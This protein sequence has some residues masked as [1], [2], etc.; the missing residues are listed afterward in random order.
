MITQ[1]RVLRQSSISAVLSIIHIKPFPNWKGIFF[2]F[3]FALTIS[4]FPQEYNFRN[5]NSAEGLPYS[6][7]YSINQ[8]SGG[9]LWIGTGNGLSRY[10]GFIFENYTTTDS[11]TD[12]FISCS[13]T[14]GKCMWFG[15]MSGQLSFFDGDKL[16]P[17]F[18][19]KLSSSPVTHFAKSPDNQI[20]ASTYSDGLLKLK[21]NGGSADHYISKDQI[22]IIS[23][24]FLG[25]NELLVGTNTG[26][27]LAR[28]NESGE[29]ERIRLF[30]EIPESKVTCIRKMR[31]KPGFY[32]ATEN[33][34]IFKITN[35]DNRLMVSKITE[36]RGFD[37]TGIQDIYE[38]SRS[39]LWLGSF[40]NGLIRI[41][42]S[43]TGETD[44][45]NYFNRSNGF[46]TDNVKTVFEDRE[47]N[48]WSGNYGEGLTQIMPRVFSVRTFNK[49]LYGNNIFS[50]FSDKLYRWIGTDNGL[51][52]TDLLTGKIA[53]FFSKG[54]GLP[55]DSVISIYSTDGKE[56][57]IG[58][59]K[60]G[61]F[62]METG[63]E[64]I[65]K[66][67]PGN[68]NLE[69][70]ITAITGKGEEVWI[71]TKKGL[72]CINS[73]TKSENWY[74]I[75]QG[76]LPHNYVNSLYIDKQ[77]RLWVTTRSNTLAY[78]QNSRVTKVPL[79]SGPGVLTLGPVTEDAENRIWVGSNG[80][81]VFLIEPDSI[82]N[83]TVKEG[84]LSN[85]CYSLICDEQKNIW[86][87]HKGGLSRIRTSDFSIKQLKSIEG[88]TESSRF[89]QNAID[90]DKTGKIWF[91]S[92]IGIVSYDPSLNN[93]RLFSPV[94]KI[95]SVKINDEEKDFS[96]KII[97]SPGNYKIRI[98]FLGISLK[99]P[100]LVTYQ[101][102]LEN[103]DQ[104]S[105][106]TKNTSI[107]YN[108]ITEGDYNFILKASSGDGI[109]T[110]NPLNLNIIIKKPIWKKWWFYVTAVIL[111]IG[112]I[113][114][115]IKRREYRFL[116]EKRLLEEKVR[117]RTY[118]IQCQKNEI[119]KQR[120]IIDEK[121][122]NITSSIR[123]ASHIQN[124]VLP[125][126]ERLNKL[127]PD[128]FIL[129][130]PKDIVSGDFYWLAEKDSKVI[131]AVADCTGHGVSGAFMSFLGIALLNEI[132]NIQ[133]ITRS[134]TIVTKLREAI[135]RS[136]QQTRKEIT[137]LDGIDI[138]LCVFDRQKRIIQYTGGMIDLLYFRDKKLVEVKADNQSV[139]LL[140]HDSGPFTQKEIDCRKGD[141]FYLFSDGFQDQF[142]GENNKKYLRHRFYCTLSEIHELTIPA[143]KESL[144]K[145]LNEWMRDNI[146]TDDITVMGFK[147]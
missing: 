119:E 102:K 147:L 54:S 101:Y 9:Y 87:G 114:T 59:E 109:V 11:L 55:K 13:V 68:E 22:F 25:N 61:V 133:G 100:E 136:L 30:T 26:L 80:N 3:F 125:D 103:Y 91:G 6:Y 130:R 106:I 24:D 81:G 56:L 62:L 37:I 72:C 121:N 64:R 99:E 36:N 145:T 76:G 118:E 127:L 16:H 31:S 146:Q 120:D 2:L 49:A 12:N 17:A 140:S 134:D 115:Y 96:D 50:I 53:K 97:L 143:Q 67:F 132:V 40:G 77:G 58:T 45:I 117:E 129:S 122:A 135:I 14:D 108:H 47:G 75:S 1:N 144:E 124:A 34:G 19:P 28:L 84:L 128:S 105:E 93:P 142:G 4:A 141:V 38:D 116:A 52:K 82:L 104:W 83:L 18:L 123:Y 131:F 10:N 60:N 8:D 21:R 111:I 63:S 138:G 29:I 66:Y 43:E 5:F 27:I 113:Y 48:I 70:S 46:L 15:H 89:N 95:I 98:D 7:V 69:N 86:V 107:I 42:F 88:I 20:W 137:T 33:D 73:V 41:I 85:Y 35:E 78:I 71:G 94:L 51:L 92:D 139:S 39:N 32:I 79:S 112:L 44:R 23:F 65:F 126:A 90:K 110:Q 57:W 74:S